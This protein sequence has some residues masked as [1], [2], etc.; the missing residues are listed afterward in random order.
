M[1]NNIGT[2]ERP[3]VDFQV[4]PVEIRWHSGLPVFASPQFLKLIAGEHGW[5][6]GTD[7]TGR[8]RFV[9]PFTVIRKPGFRLIRFPTETVALG[10]EASVG[11]EKSFLNAV[12]RQLSSGSADLILP[13]NNTALFRTYPNG[14]AA[15]PYGTFLKDLNQSEEALWREVSEAYRKDIRR[16][17]KNG[18]EVHSGLE[19]MPAAHNMIATTLRR[20][21]MSFKKYSEFESLVLGLG[22]HVKVFAAVRDGVVQ[23]CLVAPFSAY[24][25]Y[26]W[27]GG[28]LA[29]PVKGSMHLVH[30][31]AIRAFRRMG[32]QRFNFT[33]V[34][35][36]PTK[37]SKQAGIAEF[38]Q[39]FG[40]KLLTGFMW[41]YSFHFLKYAA[42]SVAIRA[43]AGGDV[44]DQERHKLVHAK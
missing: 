31:E 42:Y 3:A 26:T 1:L 30:W 18:V 16:A 6:G 20:S 21:G 14:A 40:G 19:Y 41:K 4:G 24:A 2:A 28:T 9:L 27:Y 12:I 44:V 10:E 32:V 35:I 34:R 33:G 36:N 7:V 39:R 11:E 29:Q 23:A 5:L 8:L 17:A 25:A 43:F 13:A 37:G 22:D 38:K 15:A